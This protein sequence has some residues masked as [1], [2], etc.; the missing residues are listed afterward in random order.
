MRQPL[1]SAAAALTTCL[2]LT[3][4][5]H[6]ATA[7]HP[8]AATSATNGVDVQALWKQAVE[9]CNADRVGTLPPA[10]PNNFGVEAAWPTDSDVTQ[11][12]AE[13]HPSGSVD[14]TE[15]R[16]V[17]LRAAEL[18]TRFEMANATVRGNREV[19]KAPGLG[20]DPQ[21]PIES[22]QETVRDLADGWK[23]ERAFLT[24]EI[25][26]GTVNVATGETVEWMKQVADTRRSA[27]R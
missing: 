22:V 14:F 4:C 20:Y 5:S 12:V 13:L 19:E 10:D 25:N 17:D 24:G 11:V 15:D 6:G 8:T 2:A 3:S 1:T 16:L 7:G 27:C 26:A 21:V 9:R 23:L 18:D